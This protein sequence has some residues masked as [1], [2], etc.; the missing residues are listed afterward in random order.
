MHLSTYILQTTL[1]VN[2][3]KGMSGLRRSITLSGPVAVF[4]KGTFGT[5]LA[6]FMGHYP[7]YT[8]SNFLEVR[9]PVHKEVL[10]Y[11]LLRAA[12]IGCIATIVSDCVTNGIR[13]VNTYRQTSSEPLTYTETVK[14][15]IKED[16]VMGLFTRGLSTKMIANCLNAIIFKV[17]LL[18]PW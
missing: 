15:V 5:M 7:W 8:V 9:V 12:A 11:T 18:L 1:Q 6:Q 2:G 4:F 10:L 16:G 17:L 13:V 14:R 3:A